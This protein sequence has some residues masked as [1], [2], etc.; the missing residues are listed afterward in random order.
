MCVHACI[1]GERRGEVV[2]RDLLGEC[3][4]SWTTV[5]FFWLLTFYVKSFLIKILKCEAPSAWMGRKDAMD[6]QRRA[7]D[8]I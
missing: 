4:S 2:K 8:W 7:P 5:S 1:Y 3:E 6:T